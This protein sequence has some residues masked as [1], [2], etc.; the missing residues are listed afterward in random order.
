MSIPMKLEKAKLVKVEGGGGG[1]LGDVA[2]MGASL[3]TSAAGI[4]GMLPVVWTETEMNF[5]FNPTQLQLGKEAN[6]QGSNTRASEEGG[7]EQFSNPGTRTLQ[8]SVLLDEWEAPVGA[9]ADVGSMVDTLQKWCNPEPGSTP[10]S[11]P[12][13]MFVWGKFRFIGQLKSVNATFNLFRRDGSPARA[14]VQVSMR[15]RPEPGQAQNPTSGGP[16][17][18]RSRRVVEGDTLPSIAYRELGDPNLW[19]VLAEMN[20]IDD[21]MSVG[22]GTQLLIPSRADAKATIR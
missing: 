21:P 22:P 7:Q 9:G 15:E 16:A 10:P 12:T 2:S 19:R 1:P 18:R 3:A 20:R 6:Y 8:F 14:E 11:P 5:R 17:G 13:A 4:G